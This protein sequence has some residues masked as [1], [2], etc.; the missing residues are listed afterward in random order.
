MT[1]ITLALLSL[2]DAF[3]RIGTKKSR[4]YA[5]IADGRLPRPIGLGRS[6]RLPAHEIDRIV[7]ALIGGVTDEGLRELS[8][9]L[10]NERAVL[11]SSA[12]AAA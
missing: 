10:M 4:G 1:Q 2:E 11:V 12:E 5:M 6:R 9:R 8:T 3:S 7:V